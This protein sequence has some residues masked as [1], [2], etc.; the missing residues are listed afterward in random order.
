M[1]CR[2]W[3][4]LVAAALLG[5][6]GQNLAPAA[7]TRDL[8]VATAPTWP[9]AAAKIR[10][11][12][13]IYQENRSLDNLF[14]GLPGADTVRSGKNSNGQTVRL[15]PI[16]LT[17]PYDVGHDHVSFETEYANGRLDGFNNVKSE[18]HRGLKCI[19]GGVRAYGYVPRKEVQPYFDLA[20]RYTFA[21]HMFQTNQGPSFPAHQ[22]IISGT[23]TIV[24]GSDLRASSNAFAPQ[25]G[26]AG[27][28]DSPP[29][30]FVRLIDEFGNEDRATY[31]CF[32]RKTLMDLLAN[33]RMS[34][35]FYVASLQPGLWNAPDAIAHIRNG[36]AYFSHVVAPSKR[37]LTD[38][39][40]GQL[41]DVVWVT[42]TQQASDHAGFTDGSGPSWVA[43]VVNAIGRSEYWNDT[44]IFVTWDDWGGWYDH[45]K[46]QMYNSYE[47]GFRVPL[48]VISPY[49]KPHH[50]SHDR[51]EFGSILKFVEATFGLPSLQTTDAR[52]AALS[53]CFDFAQAPIR[54]QAVG[55][56]YS[57]EYFL[58]QPLSL[59]YSDDD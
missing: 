2:T 55:A 19:P 56:K 16:S 14:N 18:C 43:S 29:G 35:R 41:A 20:E 1:S 17:A 22:Y 57:E 39:A 59:Q 4:A 47:L 24:D 53:D 26:F 5:S 32:E 28:C 6:C 44:V 23:S 27:G 54:F 8:P 40:H 48:I 52:A 15:A 21:D 45:V 25:K 46:P 38:V 49:A 33:R 34:W 12:V 50:V 10:H 7:A 30:S 9:A 11:V 42:P 58:R 13:I 31:P 36:N 51:Y 37:I 3:P